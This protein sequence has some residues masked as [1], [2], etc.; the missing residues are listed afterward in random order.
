MTLA[1]ERSPCGPSLHL[2]REQ[3]AKVFGRQPAHRRVVVA[4]SAACTSPIRETREESRKATHAQV[5]ASF[6]CCGSAERLCSNR[7]D[8]KRAMQ[9]VEPASLLGCHPCHPGSA[10]SIEHQSS[11]VQ[12]IHVQVRINEF[13]HCNAAVSFSLLRQ[14]MTSKFL[15]H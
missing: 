7:N 10:S 4:Q 11:L 8:T 6:S 3:K 13:F 14:Y 12:K 1:A 15:S 2:Q 9:L 5:I